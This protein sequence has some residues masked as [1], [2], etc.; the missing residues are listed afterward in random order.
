M[1]RVFQIYKYVTCT[2]DSI[3][4]LFFRRSFISITDIQDISTTKRLVFIFLF[5]MTD[6][7]GIKLFFFPLSQSWDFLIIF[8]YLLLLDQYL[9]GLSN[10]NNWQIFC[11]VLENMKGLY[12]FNN[13]AFTSQFLPFIERVC[14]Q[15]I[16][17]RHISFSFSPAQSSL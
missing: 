7:L 5:I 16:C 12:F 17:F 1:G 2:H 4:K 10:Y 11:N 9:A 15:Y 6:I 8:Y 13:P 3:G 14:M